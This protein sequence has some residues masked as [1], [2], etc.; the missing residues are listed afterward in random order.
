M[1]AVF[2]IDPHSGAVT[3][4]DVLDRETTSTYSVRV[5][6]SDGGPDPLSSTTTLTVLVSDNNDNPPVFTKDNYITAGTL[7]L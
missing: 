5:V 1:R 4:T 6:A 2:L 3:L 7:Y